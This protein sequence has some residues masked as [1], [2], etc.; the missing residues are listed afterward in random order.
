M[1]LGTCMCRC[2]FPFEVYMYVVVQ[3]YPWFNFDFPL[4]FSI[5]IYEN[6]YYTKEN[7]FIEPRIKWNYNI[8]YTLL[9]LIFVFTYFGE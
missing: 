8:L 1:E 9:L 2:L 6:K 4:F 3:F 5:L 7:Q